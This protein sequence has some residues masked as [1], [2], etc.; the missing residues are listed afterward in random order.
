[1]PPDAPP[2]VVLGNGVIAGSGSDPR[3]IKNVKG[4]IQRGVDS[5]DG[6][7]RAALAREPGLAANVSRIAA[8]RR[9][10]VRPRPARGL[11]RER[12]CA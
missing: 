10:V 8:G 11:R 5:E 9:G 7:D 4:T 12:A 1:M 6:A 3:P 2:V